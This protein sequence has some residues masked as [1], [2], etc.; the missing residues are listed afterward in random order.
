MIQLIASSFFLF[1][2]KSFNLFCLRRQK[3]NI[4]FYGFQA[5]KRK[6]HVL[7]VFFRLSLQRWDLSHCFRPEIWCIFRWARAL[8]VLPASSYGGFIGALE[9]RPQCCILFFFAINLFGSTLTTIITEF[10]VPEGGRE[11]PFPAIRARHTQGQEK[12]RPNN[13]MLW[14]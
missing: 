9:F 2:H 3:T 5:A 10:L 14:E 13:K 7:K 12:R 8:Y 6:K 4:F 1:E 11:S